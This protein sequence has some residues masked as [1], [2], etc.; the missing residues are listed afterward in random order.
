M[1]DYFQLEK[2][3]LKKIQAEIQHDIDRQEQRAECQKMIDDAIR[4]H[5]KQILLDIH[6]ILNGNPI[7]LNSL[8]DEIKKRLISE[9]QKRFK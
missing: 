2:E 3:R 4:E 9:L 1:T 5:D 7:A 6:T 8:A